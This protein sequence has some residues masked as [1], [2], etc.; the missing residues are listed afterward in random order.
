M[1]VVQLG[2]SGCYRI[3]LQSGD[4][5]YAQIN[6]VLLGDDIRRRHASRRRVR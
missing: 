5:D 1:N 2:A 4:A 3:H 6:A